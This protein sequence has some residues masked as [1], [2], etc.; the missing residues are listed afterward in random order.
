MSCRNTMPN[1]RIIIKRRKKLFLMSVK[2]LIK[3]ELS[4]IIMHCE[5]VK[6]IHTLN[7]K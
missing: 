5:I 3:I 1:E 2:L 6:C 4:K 7:D